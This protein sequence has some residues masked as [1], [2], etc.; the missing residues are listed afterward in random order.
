MGARHG[1]R[2]CAARVDRPALPSLRAC[3][4][5]EELETGGNAMEGLMVGLATRQAPSFSQRTAATGTEAVLI[6]ED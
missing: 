5:F 3:P 6:P 1:A 4:H 2:R